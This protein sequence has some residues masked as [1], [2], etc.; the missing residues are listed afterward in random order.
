MDRQMFQ[1]YIVTCQSTGK[2]YI[3]ITS[4]GLRRRWHEHVYNA[5][6]QMNPSALYAAIRRYGRDDFS[7][8]S[9]CVAASV[10][11]IR[12]VESALIRQWGTLAPNG[13]NLTLG[14]EGRFGFRPSPDSVEQSAAKHRG[15]PCHPNTK[16]AAALFHKGRTRS[17]E[18]RARISA[19]RLGQPRSEATK[20]KLRL[21]W[22]ERRARGEFKTAQ[23]YDHAAR[24]AASAHIAKIPLA[25]STWIARAWYPRAERIA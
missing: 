14:G 3:G 2:R 4:A 17:H 19:A 18:H 16:A 9:V 21:Y 15:R 5:K 10:N 11:D 20:E 12:A 1:A 13:Y 22:A 6:R 24:K 23:P 25:L 7:I 8:E